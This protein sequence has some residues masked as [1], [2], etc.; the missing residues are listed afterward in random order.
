MQRVMAGAGLSLGQS[1][2]GCYFAIVRNLV[3]AGGG[4]AIVDPIN[5]KAHLDDGVVWRPFSPR[6]VH[7]LPLL[8]HKDR[9][10]SI[11][12]SRFNDY[13]R[14]ALKPYEIEA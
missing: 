8:T 13:I 10:L 4:V 9:P 6:I 7:E 11:T 12:A 3:A 2:N 1:V 5:G 14:D